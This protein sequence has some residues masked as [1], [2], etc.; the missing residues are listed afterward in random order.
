MGEWRWWRWW[1]W[2]L[3]VEEGSNNAGMTTITAGEAVFGIIRKAGIVRPS[4]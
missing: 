4:R 3:G 2:W 1:R